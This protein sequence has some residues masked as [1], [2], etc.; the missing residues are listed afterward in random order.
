MPVNLLSDNMARFI[1]LFVSKKAILKCS[2]QGLHGQPPYECLFTCSLAL[3]V[4]TDMTVDLL[5]QSVPTSFS[6]FFP[7]CNHCLSSCNTELNLINKGK[8]LHAQTLLGKK[9]HWKTLQHPYT[10]NTFTNLWGV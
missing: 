7:L 1:T 3:A 10:I 6:Y 4:K 5:L 9:P 2:H 8:V